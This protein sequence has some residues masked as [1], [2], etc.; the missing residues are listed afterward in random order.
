MITLVITAC[1][2][3]DLLER[4]L[5]S[6]Y[7]RGAWAYNDT[8][9]LLSEIIIIEDSGF[10]CNDHLIRKYYNIKW[11]ANCKRKGQ[12][13]SIDRAYS[14]AK[15]EYILHWEEDFEC[16]EYL[17]E[18]INQSIH[19]LSTYPEVCMVGLRG[20][21]DTMTQPVLKDRDYLYLDPTFKGHWHGFRFNPG[22]RRLSDWKKMGGYAKHTTF[23]FK[24]PADSEIDIAKVYYNMGMVA[25]LLPEKY[26]EH[27]GR[28]RH[29]E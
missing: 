28:G 9:K 8:A 16:V 27:I 4:T 7:C 13:L 20:I 14:I 25:A 22:L 21:E 19:I 17:H 1:G 3:P 5:D 2:R 24:S 10:E 26:V 6:L 12:I 15:Y 29:V 11:L 18:A 23:N